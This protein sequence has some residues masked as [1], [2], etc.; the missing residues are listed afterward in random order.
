VRIRPTDD[1]LW[2]AI[3]ENTDAMSKL[4]QQQIELDEEIGG[5]NPDD[6]AKLMLSN[7]QMI[8]VYQRDYREFVA[9]I[10]RRYPAT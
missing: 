10:R 5:P 2:C 7:V 9:E 3:A 6:R 4:V 8:E 1:E